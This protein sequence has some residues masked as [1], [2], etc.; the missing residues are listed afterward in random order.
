MISLLLIHPANMSLATY[1]GYN[2]FTHVKLL[3]RDTQSITQLLYHI[4][5]PSASPAYILMRP[6]MSLE[7]VIQLTPSLPVT[8]HDFGIYP[9]DFTHAHISSILDHR[10]WRTA[11]FASSTHQLSIGLFYL[12]L[13]QKTGPCYI[14]PKRVAHRRA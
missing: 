5:H 11:S 6:C 10:I 2:N 8:T 4:H 1:H 13:V 3:L 14:S 12:H 7:G 9:R